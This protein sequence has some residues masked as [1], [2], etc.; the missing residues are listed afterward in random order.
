MELNKND[1][2]FGD[3]VQG[4]STVERECGMSGGR[5]YD[6]HVLVCTQGCFDVGG[7]DV[8]QAM[9]AE[10]EQRRMDDVKLSAVRDLGFCDRGPTAVIY[11]E[12]VWYE[13][14][15]TGEVSRIVEE[16]LNGDAPVEEL[17]FNPDLPWN[18]KLIV[19]CTFLSQCG[20]EGGGKVYKGFQ[21]R[22][23]EVDNVS[24]IQSYGCLKECSMG[25]VVCVYPDGEWFTGLHE[26]QLDEIWESSIVGSQRSKFSTGSI[27]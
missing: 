14:L 7:F 15:T 13:G 21:Q 12:G 4:Y 16:H 11:P 5:G 23:T 27:S 6:K 10:L 18:H 9:Y 8:K 22:A 17:T 26:H 19:C 20:P 3:A 24:V 25:P 2:L 1:N